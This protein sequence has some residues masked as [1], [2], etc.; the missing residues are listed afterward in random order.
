MCLAHVFLAV[1]ESV[2]LNR[3]TQGHLGHVTLMVKDLTCARENVKMRHLEG[4]LDK[5]SVSHIQVDQSDLL[6]AV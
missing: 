3:W 1:T 5:Q 4:L 2:H 6:L